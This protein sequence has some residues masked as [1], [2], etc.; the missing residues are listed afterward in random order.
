LAA[1][2]AGALTNSLRRLCE[3]NM[4]S[5]MEHG[6]YQFEDEAFA[7]WSADCELDA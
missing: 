1:V 4:L 2:T 5:R 3:R 7:E 6:K